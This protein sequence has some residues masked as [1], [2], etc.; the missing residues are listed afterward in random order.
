MEVVPIIETPIVPIIKLKK[1]KVSKFKEKYN[2]NPEYR[3]RHL[4]RTKEQIKCADCGCVISRSNMCNHRETNKHKKLVKALTEAK[5]ER[6][7]V[8]EAEKYA[9]E[10]CETQQTRDRLIN[11]LAIKIE[12]LKTNLNNIKST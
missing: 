12:E 8:L 6:D 5:A 7:K 3:A 10:T 1:K 9:R 11:E 2:S 4:A